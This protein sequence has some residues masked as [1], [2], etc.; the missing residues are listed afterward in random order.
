MGAGVNTVFLLGL[1]LGQVC[2]K[3]LC[4][5]LPVVRWGKNISWT[6]HGC[7]IVLYRHA[8][9]R[10]IRSCERVFSNSCL[11]CTQLPLE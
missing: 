6:P 8:L 7:W 10:A 2:C 3:A 4:F 9:R 5:V 1:G 11:R